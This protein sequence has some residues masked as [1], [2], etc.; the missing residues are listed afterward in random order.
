MP[1]CTPG[2]G[3]HLPGVK[4]ASLIGRRYSLPTQD[5]LFLPESRGAAGCLGTA[6]PSRDVGGSCWPHLSPHTA[7]GL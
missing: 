3:K 6:A 4:D 7:S 2:N 5:D 1:Q